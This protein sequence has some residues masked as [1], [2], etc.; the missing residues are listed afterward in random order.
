MLSTSPEIQVVGTAGNGKEALELIPQLKPAVI[1]TDLHMPVMDG[2]ELTKRVMEVYPTPILVV[3]VSVQKD[4]VH[5]IFRLLEA[6][7]VDVMPKPRNGLDSDYER[8]TQELIQKVKVLSGVLV[9]R[10]Q[11]KEPVS[12]RK[13]QPK[14][15]EMSF[16]IV[17]IGASTGGP[18]A[19][20]KILTQLP[21]NFPLP[22]ICVQHISKGFMDGFV[23]WLIPQCRMTIKIAQTGEFPIPGMIYF[24]PEGTHLTVDNK[25]RLITSAEPSQNGFCPSITVTMKSVADTYGSKAVGILLTGM[26]KDGAEGMMAIAQAGGITVAQDEESSVVFGMPKAAIELGA[27]RYVL[28]PNDIAGMLVQLRNGNPGGK[29]KNT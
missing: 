25:G 23:D 1:C 26:G 18:Q 4:R 7:A 2:F 12:V 21:H 9:F 22:V 15:E 17:V 13:V 28:P 14:I 10:K 24:A 20:Q 29:D 5:N 3:S 6:G 16:R 19:L 8:L 27:A 11:K